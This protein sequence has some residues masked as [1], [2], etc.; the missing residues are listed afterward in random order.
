MPG[1]PAFRTRTFRGVFLAALLG[2]LI[3][4]PVASAALAPV[5]QDG[6][7]RSLT[8]L[9]TPALRAQTPARQAAQLD[10]ARSGPGSLLRDGRRIDVKLR[11]ASGAL[12]QL[13]ELRG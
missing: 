8:K 1:V 6:L 12:G 11:F 9:A 13:G 4:A 2:C 10:V 3:G 7:S 5:G